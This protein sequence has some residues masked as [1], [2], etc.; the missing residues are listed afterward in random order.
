MGI[1]SRRN[2]A[3]LVYF[4]FL[5]SYLMIVY[6]FTLKVS[7]NSVI[8]TSYICEKGM[9]IEIIEKMSE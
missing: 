1:K 6:C 8:Q 4:I 7:A 2:R 5:F 9:C 3:T